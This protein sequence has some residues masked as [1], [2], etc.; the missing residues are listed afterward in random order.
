MWFGGR[1][2][3]LEAYDQTVRSPSLEVRVPA[4]VRHVSG[5]HNWWATK[6]VRFNRR[7]V[8]LRDGGRCQYCGQKVSPELATY[9]H[10]VPR[11]K[12]GRTTWDNIV[13]CCFSC[14][15][16][17]GDQTP[18]AARMRLLSDPRKPRVGTIPV[19][20]GLR[21]CRQVPLDVPASWLPYLGKSTG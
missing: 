16:R 11:C 13:T 15:Q 3:I 20:P 14:N 10:L 17:K 7:T 8:L 5:T 4:V 18:E 9:D 2:E 6:G 21:G 12:G 19:L 1:A